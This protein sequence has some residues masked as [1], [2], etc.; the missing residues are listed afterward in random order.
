M[1]L[2]VCGLSCYLIGSPIAKPHH[3]DGY[4]GLTGKRA[5]DSIM[6]DRLVERFGAPR[7]ISSNCGPQFVR[8]NFPTLCSKTG[9]G[10][11]GMLK[12]KILASS[13][14]VPFLKPLPW[15]RALFGCSFS[16]L[17]GR[18]M[19]LQVLQ[20]IRHMKLSLVRTT[21]L[22]DLLLHKQGRSPKM[23]CTIFKNVR[24][25]SLLHAGL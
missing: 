8:Q 9:S 13:R 7:D 21:V 14:G 23:P 17:Y 2:H 19:R 1:L 25:F 22:K 15:K 20:V 11:K 16:P 18:G 3:E 24:S 4:E 12:R 6:M 5:A 10:T